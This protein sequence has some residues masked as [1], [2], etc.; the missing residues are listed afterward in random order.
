MP[1][2]IKENNVIHT[3][4]KSS[5][6]NPGLFLGFLVVPVLVRCEDPF[7]AADAG[8]RKA[9]KKARDDTQQALFTNLCIHVASK[10]PVLIYDILPCRCAGL[11][12]DIGKPSAP[13]VKP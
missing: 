9:P 4:P 13:A 2:K 3:K 12:E 8:R 6:K 1:K 11:S 7:L 5:R 10:V